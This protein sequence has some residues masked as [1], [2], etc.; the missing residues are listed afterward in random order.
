VILIL[1]QGLL[2]GSSGG[3]KGHCAFAI[4]P[5]GEKG[6]VALL[7]FPA[8]DDLREIEKAGSVWASLFTRD[9]FSEKDFEFFATRY[10]TF[11][12]CLK[13]VEGRFQATLPEFDPFT[14]HEHC[15]TLFAPAFGTHGALMIS[16]AM[17][18]MGKVPDFKFASFEAGVIRTI[19][20]TWQDMKQKKRHG[21]K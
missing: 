4:P 7:Q 9:I 1:K 8:T 19:R 2:F 21:K 5:L 12:E 14:Q 17:N 11:Y 20:R 10:Q 18:P 15:R 13:E 16:P 3:I 6:D